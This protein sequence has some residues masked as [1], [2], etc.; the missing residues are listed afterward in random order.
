MSAVIYENNL[1]EFRF[2]P[3][4]SDGR[5]LCVMSDLYGSWTE[6][7]WPGDEWADG[8][9]LFASRSRAERVARRQQRR[10]RRE[11]RKVFRE[12]GSQP[13]GPGTSDAE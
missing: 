3:E 2:Q 7:R 11:D 4:L 9:K 12:R 6:W 10:E 8:P 5:R 13:T 1:N